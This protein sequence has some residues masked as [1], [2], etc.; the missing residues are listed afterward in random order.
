MVFTEFYDIVEERRSSTSYKETPVEKEKLYRILESLTLAPSWSC[1]HCY[2]VIVVD[3]GELKK[4]IAE[5]VDEGNSA[6]KGLLQAPVVLIMCA[7]PVSAEEID[8]KE[9]YMCDCGIAMEHIMLAAH[10]EGLAT[11]WIGLF[12][13]DR[14]KTLLEIPDPIRLVAISPLGYGADADRD[15][16]TKKSIKDITYHE[17]WENEL[18]FK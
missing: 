15:R 4:S 2:R 17:K 12:D 16:S 10:N 3:E 5:C 18:V 14:L 6:R 1:V 9:Y 7:D 11:C 13:E 8:N